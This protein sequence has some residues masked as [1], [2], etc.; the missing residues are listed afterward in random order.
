MTVLFP[1]VPTAGLDERT[2]AR[3]GATVSTVPAFPYT[4][5]RT[6]WSA[7]TSSG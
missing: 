6:E 2:L 4:F 5:R 3:V 7:T 1:F